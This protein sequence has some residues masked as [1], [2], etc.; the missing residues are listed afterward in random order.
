MSDDERRGE[1]RRRAPRRRARTP[2]ESQ[3]ACAPSRRAVSSSPAPPARATWAVVPYWRKLK[4]A[5][6]PPR[7]VERDAERRELRAA[8]VP[9]DRRVDEEVERLGRERAQRR[10]REP[11]DLAVV[12]R[13][14]RQPAAAI[15][16]SYAAT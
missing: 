1:E 4:I 15:V 8:E 3:T 9:D 11:D 5:N 12:L 2:S 16:A 13:P 10:E 14:E 7:I 6:V